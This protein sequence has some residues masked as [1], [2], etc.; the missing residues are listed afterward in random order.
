MRFMT[1]ALVCLCAL[2]AVDSI[3]FNGVYFSTL[4]QMINSALALR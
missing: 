3:W 2:Y 1:S 4:N